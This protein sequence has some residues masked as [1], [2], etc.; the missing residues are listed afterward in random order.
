MRSLKNMIIYAGQLKKKFPGTNEQ[1]IIYKALID[2]NQSKLIV[3]DLQFYKL[4]LIDLFPGVTHAD[5]RDPL[6]V[7]Q[8][9]ISYKTLNLTYNEDQV[10][11]IFDLV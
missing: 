9:K 4:L 8:I 10:S 2:M 5:E 7:E 6:M 1:Q 3:T 11:I